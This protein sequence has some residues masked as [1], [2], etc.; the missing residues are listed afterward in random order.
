MIARTIAKLLCSA[1]PLLS[2]G[3]C[4]AV[5][6]ADDA[7]ALSPPALD[8]PMAATP[9]EEVAVFAGGCFWGIQAVFEH[10]KGVD[11]ATAGY[12]GGSADT[13]HYDMVSGGDTGHAES[14][15][16]SFNPS[17][18]SYGT[19]LQ[20]F[21]SVALDPTELDRQGPDVGSQYRSVIFYASAEQKR[22]ASAYL[23]QLAAAKAFPR[24]IA[25]QLT[26]LEAF[27]PA[28]SYHQDYYRKHPDS[29]YIVVNDKP[30]VARLRQLFPALY[31]PERQ[32]V[33]VQ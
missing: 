11:Q 30:K 20:A 10:I 12:A 3:A 22:I 23:A 7:R 19:L 31:R 16:V 14:V 17:R 8:A 21:F 24:P 26:P 5:S 32:F 13:A 33:E 4:N 15:R 28:E 25:T 6:A 1:L 18:V 2:V 9:R 27:Y 29:L